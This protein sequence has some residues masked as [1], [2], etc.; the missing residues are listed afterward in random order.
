MNGNDSCIVRFVSHQL[1]I[2]PKK[3]EGETIKKRN[4]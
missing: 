4:N 2:L 3:L 1:N